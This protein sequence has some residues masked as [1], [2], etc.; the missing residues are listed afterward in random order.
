MK[1]FKYTGLVVCCA[2]ILFSVNAYALETSAKSS[3]LI[4]A[5]TFEILYEHNVYEQL[6]M[7]STT[8]IMTALL[9]A[10]Q[11][12][13][14]RIVTATES[15]VYIEGSAMGLKPGDTVSFKDLLY[16]ILLPSGNDAANTAA[17][18]IAGSLE[19][20]A[21]LMNNKVSELGLYN[22]NFVTPSGLDA[23][24]HYTTA[25]DLAVISAY[26]LKNE[27]FAEAVATESKTVTISGKQHL[28]VNHNKLLKTY[29]GA[30]GVKTGYTSS[31]GRCLVSAAKKGNTKL[32]AVT[33]NDK[34]DWNDHTNML[35]YGFSLTYD[36][37]I[38]P[39]CNTTVSV[40]S[41][42]EINLKLYFK[43]HSLGVT[44]KSNITYKIF[45]HKLLYATPNNGEVIGY[46]EF[47]SEERLISVEEISVDCVFE[48]KTEKS[49]FIKK[50]F[51]KYLKLLESF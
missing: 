35:N 50:L 32:I 29:S 49:N 27:S 1:I 26:A 33:L 40:L 21:L 34:N 47:Y 37:V 38:V 14:D 19:S 8:K 42:N 3:I 51:I 22:T 9:L 6:P 17:I 41:N 13:P 11:N 25:Y 2:L 43:S 7:A 20:F 28:L 16:G 36:T 4:N 18:S 10:E 23:D 24:G 48:N 31:S 5:D 44:D 46:T 45:L 12:T 39:N 30:I 15:A